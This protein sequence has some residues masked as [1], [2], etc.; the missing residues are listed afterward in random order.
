MITGEFGSGRDHRTRLHSGHRLFT[1]RSGNLRGDQLGV[2]RP[3][4]LV[5]N[6][7]VG[8]YRGAFT[9]PAYNPAAGGGTTTTATTLVTG[10]DD[11]LHKKPAVLVVDLS[12]VTFF[13]SVGITSLIEGER[14]THGP[15]RVVGAP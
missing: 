13:G 4:A 6:H 1:S 3:V 9:Q 12:E 2:R 10:I 11:A 5:R 8:S 7:E 14:P 15:M